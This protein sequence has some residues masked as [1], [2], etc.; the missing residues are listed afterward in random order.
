MC[1][2]IA[3]VF[4]VLVALH[5]SGRCCPRWCYLSGLAVA[6]FAG[7]R[8]AACAPL[9]VQICLKIQIMSLLI[10][11]LRRLVLQKKNSGAEFSLMFFYSRLVDEFTLVK[12]TELIGT[13]GVDYIEADYA[14]TDE[15]R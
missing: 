15:R 10:S 5:R 3:C 7:V 11:V 4:S 14:E 9:V 2:K 12:C 6:G 1:N 8:C 13:T